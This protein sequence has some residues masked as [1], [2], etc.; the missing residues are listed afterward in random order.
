[1]DSDIREP[2]NLGSEEA[3]TVNELI[4]LVEKIASKNLSKNY[5]LSKPQGVRGRNSNNTKLR[6]LL[7]WEP[8]ITLKEGL[9][10]T[11]S[12]IESE[13]SKSQKLKAG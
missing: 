2:L 1:M 6:E 4:D 9:R 5:D 8:G 12:W 13:L 10:D 11:Y 7:G 3:I